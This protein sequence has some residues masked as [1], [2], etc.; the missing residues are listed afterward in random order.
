MEN[1]I[2]EISLSLLAAIANRARSFEASKAKAE[3]RHE[4]PENQGTRRHMKLEALIQRRSKQ[5][6]FKASSRE[7]DSRPRKRS[8]S[9]QTEANQIEQRQ[10]H[11]E[12][13]KQH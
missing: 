8:R 3:A 6:R 1:L 9:S 12:K 5:R 2:H 13:A 10:E 11:D 4:D 7:G